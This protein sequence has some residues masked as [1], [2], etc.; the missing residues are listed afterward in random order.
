MTPFF[1]NARCLYLY[2]SQYTLFWVEHLLTFSKDALHRR[3]SSD[4]SFCQPTEMLR[5]GCNKSGGT[6]TTNAPTTTAPPLAPLNALLPESSLPSGVSVNDDTTWNI[7]A[8]ILLVA[9][10]ERVLFSK[11]ICHPDKCV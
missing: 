1:I 11:R 2:N 3:Y 5:T 10:Q 4:T 9:T 7:W 6:T 8:N